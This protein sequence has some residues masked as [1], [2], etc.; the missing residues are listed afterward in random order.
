MNLKETILDVLKNYLLE[1][2]E[3]AL[4]GEEVYKDKPPFLL[5]FDEYYKMINSMDKYHEESAYNWSYNPDAKFECRPNSTCTLIRT[6]NVGNIELKYYMIK[7][8]AQYAKWVNDEFLGPYSD[9]ELKEMGKDP[10]IY[11]IVCTH[12]NVTVGGG[13]DEWGCVLIYVVKEYRGLGIGEELVK[14]YREI[15]PYKPSGGLTDSGYQQF[16]KYYNWLVKRAL[17]S[18][19]YSKLIKKGELTM[20]RAKEIINSVDKNYKFSEEKKG[21]LIKFLKGS[22]GPIYLINKTF[23]VIFD[24]SFKDKYQEAFDFGYFEEV[25]LKNHI[26]SYVSLVDFNGY[27]QV[28]ACYGT[29][30]YIREAIAILSNLNTEGIGDYYFRNFEPEIKEILNNIWNNSN[31]YDKETIE[32]EGYIDSV[33]LNV[34]KPKKNILSLINTL[35]QYSN[36]W[37]KKYDKYGEIETSVL[38]AAESLT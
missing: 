35:K 21:P 16:K 8:K 23:V 38:E 19:V 4:T 24:S 22:D 25:F 30:K 15:Y 7:E 2:Y 31:L 17:S 14:M 12:N 6:K 34:I 37:F 9:E 28:Y 20:D 11:D 32:G 10:F 18:G 27:L 36:A 26:H 13:Q 1:E 29:D 5:T 33:P 3:P